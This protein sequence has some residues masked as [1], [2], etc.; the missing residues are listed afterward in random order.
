[1][2]RINLARPSPAVI[3]AVLALVAALGGTAV[4]GSGN[5]ATTSVSKKKTKNIAKKQAKKQDSKQ[6]KRNFPV[7]S[8]QIADGAVVAAKIAGSAV[9]SGKIKKRAVGSGKIDAAA[10][11]TGKIADA[12]VTSSKI[13]DAA[14]GVPGYAL[15]AASGFVNDEEQRGVVGTNRP[16]TGVYCFDLSFAAKVVVASAET[17]PT[18]IAQGEAPG[19][20]AL[21]PVG[22]RDADVTIVDLAETAQNTGFY[23]LFN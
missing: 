17:G 11:K 20:A 18:R 12:A 4:A 14:K 3:V 13:A 23:V 19:S 9:T 21:C 8:S 15:V 2:S 10:V 7:D 6:D 5:D 16:D 1:M 22:F